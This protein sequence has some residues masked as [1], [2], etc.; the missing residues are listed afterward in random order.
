MNVLSVGEC[1]AILAKEGL[2]GM[3]M[4]H[5]DSREKSSARVG[6]D[7]EY[8]LADYMESDNCP[9]SSAIIA[10]LAGMGFNFL[11]DEFGA[12]EVEDEEVEEEPRKAW[13]WLKRR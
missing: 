2:S 13:G 12:E 3:D 8:D 5:H 11:A 4:Q 1:E 6:A 9:E 10:E 7:G